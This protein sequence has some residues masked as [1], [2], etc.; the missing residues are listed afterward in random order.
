MASLASAA[1]AVRAASAR[2][3]FLRVRIVE[4]ASLRR[5]FWPLITRVLGCRF[6]FQTLRVFFWENGTLFPNCFPLPVMSHAYDTSEFLQNNFASVSDVGRQ[7][8]NEWARERNLIIA[9]L[10]PGPGPRRH[11]YVGSA[12]LLEDPGFLVCFGLSVIAPLV[13]SGEDER[14]HECHQD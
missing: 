6:G 13:D 11:P 5:T 1:L 14:R 4:V 12:R 3:H 8:N 9:A 10:S 2:S 7:V